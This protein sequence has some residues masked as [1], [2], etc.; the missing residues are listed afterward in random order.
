PGPGGLVFDQ[1][2]LGTAGVI[3]TPGGSQVQEWQLTGNSPGAASV[4]TATTIMSWSLSASTVWAEAAV[5]LTPLSTTQVQASSFTVTQHA[6]RNL[7]ELTT[8][9]EVSS[10]G[11]NLYREENGTRAKL[12]SSL[13]AGT[14]LLAGSATAL[15]AGHVHTWYD[16][17][18]GDSSV[19]Y[20]AEE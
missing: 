18:S 10:L 8:G 15:T 5:G 1:M 2:A 17:P 9:R 13:L 19:S 20:W 7:I 11:F 16:A 12:K 6:D 3:A 4:S 14:A